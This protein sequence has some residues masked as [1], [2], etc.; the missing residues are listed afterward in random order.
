MAMHGRLISHEQA[1]EWM[2]IPSVTTTQSLPAPR[3]VPM[4]K[5]NWSYQYRN[6]PPGDAWD[7][8]LWYEVGNFTYRVATGH[9]VMILRVGCRLG[10][11]FYECSTEVDRSP[12]DMG[13]MDEDELIEHSLPGML[14][15]WEDTYKDAILGNPKI[16]TKFPSQ[17]LDTIDLGW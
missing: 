9:K 17:S 15:E 5:F 10:G 14:Q 3:E 8:W 2:G 12:V 7:G 16:H 4:S 1:W 6:L 13:L 11:S